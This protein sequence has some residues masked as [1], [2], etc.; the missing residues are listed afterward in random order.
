M[1]KLKGVGVLGGLILAGFLLLANFPA[2]GESIQKICN[3]GLVNVSERNAC[4][5]VI[6]VLL[7]VGDLNQTVLD[8]LQDVLKLGSKTSCLDCIAKVQDL[9]AT[10]GANGTAEDI[11]NAVDLACERFDHSLSLLC[12]NE[13]AIQAIPQLIDNILGNFAPVATCIDLGFCE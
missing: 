8:A 13:T 1:R 11:I 10:L 6:S 3:Q 2:A 5:F 9:E 7:D 12:A 4:Q